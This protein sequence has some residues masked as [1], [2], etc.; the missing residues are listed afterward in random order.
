LW[1]K[2]TIGRIKWRLTIAY[3]AII[4]IAI[5]AAGLVLSELIER[6]YN[7]GYRT[8][9]NSHAGLVG[10]V[11]EEE[12]H[13]GMSSADADRLCGDLGSRINARVQVIDPSGGIV[14]DSRR[15]TGDGDPVEGQ[16]ERLQHPGCR[17]CHPEARSSEVLLVDQP[18]VISGRPVGK[19]RV[20]ISLFGVRQARGRVQRVTLAALVA[21]AL[22]AVALGQRLASSIA[23]PITDMSRVASRMAEGDLTQR[24][25]ATGP[26]EIGQLAAS[27]NT[28]ALQLERMLTEMAEDK[29]KMETI[30]TTMADGIIVT[31]EVGR[32]RLFNKAS[33]GIFGREAQETLGRPI[34]DLDLHPELAKMVHETLSTRRLVRREIRLPGPTEVQL[35]VY[36]SPVKDVSSGV[37]GAVVVLHDLTGI[38]RHE[39]AQKEFVGNVS[40]ELRTPITAVLVTAEALLSGAKENP[41]LLDRFLATLVHESERLSQL[42]DDLLEVAERD[43]GRR[44][45]RRS[46]VLL[47]E[48]ADRVFALCRAKAQRNHMGMTL[49]VP[50]DLVVYADEQQVE[51]VLANLVDNAVKYTL[52]G[53]TVTLHAEENGS[54]VSFSVSDTGIGI[55]QGEVSRIFERFYRVD[56]ARSRQL[57]GTGLG[58]SIVKDI[59]DAHGGTIGVET[60]LDEGSTFTVTLPKPAPAT[61]EEPAAQSAPAA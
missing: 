29:D 12:Y 22:L 19:A 7:S 53:G 27:F 10:N 56:K 3:V 48:V 44:E 49:D 39:R 60:Q 51:Q 21:A 55:P 43:S 20:S 4:F 42:I 46:D 50:E 61:R 32:V 9:L 41:K 38:R 5:S 24:V 23:K 6:E 35:S 30:L 45:V 40:H 59:V 36:S 57:G 37:K 54:S 33:E 28:M 58:L 2:L 11:L 47:R 17:V 25:D 1:R 18:I 31:D 14:G 13:P 8:V 15:G 26:D 34:A 16:A 52:E